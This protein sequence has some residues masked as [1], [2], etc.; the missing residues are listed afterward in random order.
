MLRAQRSFTKSLEPPHRTRAFLVG[1][2]KLV[3]T[4]MWQSWQGSFY[5]SPEGGQKSQR[6]GV[7]DFGILRGEEP[8]I[9]RNK[10]TGAVYIFGCPLRCKTCYQPEFFGRKARMEFSVSDLA[11][12]FLELQREGAATL[13]IVMATLQK[14]VVKALIKAKEMGLSIDCVLNYSG[15]V[16]SKDLS[17]VQD[18][19]E[20]FVP[21][22]KALSEKYR[23]A[24]ALSEGYTKTALEGVRYL[25]ESQKNLIVRH[26]VLSPLP[27]PLSDIRILFDWM[28][29]QAFR[30]PLSIL[31]QYLCPIEKRLFSLSEELLSQLHELSDQFRVP[32]FLQGSGDYDYKL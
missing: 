8:P 7:N 4:D 1:D 26:L 30:F 14:P 13:S 3:I 10:G 32:I 31:T 12:L 9:D 11:R 24:H 6:V 22:V 23:K 20:I 17:E 21:D 27:D 2:D 28:N 25:A 5:L 16:S 18:L 19:F 29:R 15:F